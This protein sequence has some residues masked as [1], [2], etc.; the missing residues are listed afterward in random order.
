MQHPEERVLAKETREELA[1]EEGARV[2]LARHGSG[3]LS[4]VDPI[5]PLK[6]SSS[7]PPFPLPVSHPSRM[8]S[9]R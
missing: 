1:R 8:T 7:L 9:V 6:V 5:A 4:T 2:V 3:F